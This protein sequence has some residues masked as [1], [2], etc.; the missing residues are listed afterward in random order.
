MTPFVKTVVVCASC[1]AEKLETNH[2]YLLFSYP[3][4]DMGIVYEVS[5]YA[6]P[7]DAEGYGPN[8]YPACGRECLM[9]LE[10]KIIAGEQ[11]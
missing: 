11:I 8:V 1:R 5:R 10:S 6:P 3:E 9:K 2:W 7:Q 4:N